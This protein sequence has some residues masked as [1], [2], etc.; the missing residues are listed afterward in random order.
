MRWLVPATVAWALLLAGLTWWSVRHDP[1]TVKEQRTL[2]QAA[3][4]TDRA[5]GRLVAALGDGAWELTPP[6]VERGCR[7]TP[8]TDGA[9][10]TRGLDVPVP[11]GSERAL[12]D[13][14]TQRLPA[15]WRAGVATEAGRPRLRADAGEFIA[16][17]GRVVA[18]G[19]VRFS[20]ATGCRPAD[21]EFGELLLAHPAG[22]ALTAALGALGRPAPV[23]AKWVT[24]PCPAG[25][26]ARTVVVT[27]GAVPASLA[28]LR[29][30]GAVLLDRPG[31]YAYRSGSAVVLADTTGDRL[32]LAA[33][34]G[35]AG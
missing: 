4:V 20:A 29:P 24:A 7:V 17:D 30:L 14:V 35:C 19:L 3:A 5:M 28:A 10:L 16:I 2:G 32:R 6:R 18:D 11:A 25:G 15:D 13:H 23:G 8:L 26:P 21:I 34:T 31:T 12:L 9:A 1:P 27:A 33:S 22:P